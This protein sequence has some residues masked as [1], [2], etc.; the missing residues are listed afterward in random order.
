MHYFIQSYYPH[1]KLSASALR[2]INLQPPHFIL[3]CLIYTNE[4]MWEPFVLAH[5][6][7]CSAQKK[8]RQ[9]RHKRN[10]PLCL[11]DTTGASA[12]VISSPT[13]SVAALA[14]K[15]SL[16]AGAALLWKIW[17]LQ[18]EIRDRSNTQD[19]PTEQRKGQEAPK[20]H[21]SVMIWVGKRF[22]VLSLQL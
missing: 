22:R 1:P 10:W 13:C 2:L 5:V 20:S 9:F 7:F 21:S 16:P 17:C 18:Q 19:P 12:C 11:Q 14:G 8:Q 3:E 4:N 6:I 15:P